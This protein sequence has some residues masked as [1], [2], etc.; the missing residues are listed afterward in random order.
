MT[1]KK[2]TRLLVISQ[3]IKRTPQGQVMWKC[4]CE[5]GNTV[6]VRGQALRNGNTKSCG[7]LRNE[8]AVNLKYTHGCA[9]NSRTTEY[10]IWKG[11]KSRCY[12]K[13]SGS[14][15]NY[16]G[17]G[18]IVC[19]RW[20]HS[21]ENF[22]SDMGERPEGD[23]SVDRIDNNSNYTPDN[24]RWA[25]R[26]E[27]CNNRRTN[28]KLLVDYDTHI[29]LLQAVKLLNTPYGTCYTLIKKHNISTL[30]EL[31]HKIRNKPSLL[32]CCK[33]VSKSS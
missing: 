1:G 24:C 30:E 19:E 13:N 3:D 31:M 25:T 9:S 4:E 26:K 5:C 32:S 28:I 23:Y 7:C 20:L 10:V 27:Q 15:H 22:L 11:I 16:G 12:N 33:V 6:V 29:T 14:Y 2:F 8:N 21:F 17:R 18:I